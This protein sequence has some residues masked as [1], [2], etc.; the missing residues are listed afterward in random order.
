M[1]EQTST[2]KRATTEI[3]AEFL[4]QKNGANADAIRQRAIRLG[5]DLEKEG[6]LGTNW[7][8]DVE[9]EDYVTGL[10]DMDA[11]SLLFGLRAT[12]EEV[13]R[14]IGNMESF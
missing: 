9:P 10:S 14:R 1:T 7:H 12:S 4:R 11:F 2:D 3:I 6:F 5:K 8:G 13:A